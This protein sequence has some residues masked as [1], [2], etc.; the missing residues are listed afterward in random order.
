[1]QPRPPVAGFCERLPSEAVN[2]LGSALYSGAF[3][4]V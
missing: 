3:V 4:H 1:L 2:H